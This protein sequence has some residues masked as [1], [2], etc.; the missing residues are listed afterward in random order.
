MRRT[1]SEVGGE[2]VDAE[3]PSIPNPEIWISTTVAAAAI[4][5]ARSPQSPTTIPMLGFRRCL[6]S[7]LVRSSSRLRRQLKSTL[8][9][10]DANGIP[11]KP[12]WS[13]N[14]LLSSYPRPTITPAT[15][16]RLHELSALLPP[17]E[18]T[19]EH[20]RLTEEVEDLVK[21]VEAVKLVDVGEVA[22]DGVP[23]GRIWAK[24]EGINLDT[25]PHDDAVDSEA[26]S[27]RAL[28]AHA[29][30]TMDGLYVVEAD[31]PRN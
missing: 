20:T 26:A 27:G 30:R 28:L 8:A 25:V 18:G 11:L 12:T 1:A 23:D 19:P 21:L 3:R 9:E 22:E 4:R 6:Q 17:E 5:R 31:K 10:V 24:G 16:K 13:V 29:S 7:T 15:L 2:V 14:E